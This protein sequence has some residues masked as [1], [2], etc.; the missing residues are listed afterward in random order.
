MMM[1]IMAQMQRLEQQADQAAA[2][3]DYASARTLLEQATAEDSESA[4]LWTKLSA[5][6]KASGDLHGALAAIDRALALAPLEFS[7]LLAR[8]VVLDNLGDPRAGQAFAN[9]LSQ[10]GPD[11]GVP[12]V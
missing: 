3:G 6:C 1:G 12:G 8:A 5:M 9:A 11:E 2:A 10:I 4:A 7:A